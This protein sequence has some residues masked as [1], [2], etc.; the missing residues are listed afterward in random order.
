[1]AFFRSD[2]YVQEKPENSS[3]VKWGGNLWRPTIQAICVSEWQILVG[4]SFFRTWT[5][6]ANQPLLNAALI[7]FFNYKLFSMSYKILFNSISVPR[8]PLLFIISTHIAEKHQQFHYG[9]TVNWIEMK[10]NEMNGA[11]TRHPL[12]FFTTLRAAAFD[13]SSEI[14]FEFQLKTFS[15]QNEFSTGWKKMI[16]VRVWN[17]FVCYYFK[18]IQTNVENNRKYG[19][20]Y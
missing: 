4:V 18:E 7:S 8:H 2:N 6:G 14:I 9:A 20:Y 15:F 11:F 12:P 17:D 1:M 3:N 16:V 5:N 19:C 10:W 13:F